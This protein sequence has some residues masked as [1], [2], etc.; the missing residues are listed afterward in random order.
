[1]HL[2]AARNGQL[3]Y[4]RMRP[5]FKRGYL[6][7]LSNQV[8]ADASSGHFHLRRLLETTESPSLEED[9][10]LL[11]IIGSV[12][13]LILLLLCITFII[14][15][16]YL[17]RRLP[18][19][20]GPKSEDMVTANEG[21]APRAVPNIYHTN[22]SLPKIQGAKMSDQTGNDMPMVDTSVEYEEL[23][24]D[25]KDRRSSPEKVIQFDETGAQ[26]Y[27]RQSKMPVRRPTGYPRYKNRPDSYSEP[28]RMVEMN[29]VYSEPDLPCTGLPEMPTVNP[30]IPHTVV[31]S[32]KV[33]SHSPIT[34]GPIGSIPRAVTGTKVPT[35][36]AVV[37]YPVPA[38]NHHAPVSK[39]HQYDV[40]RGVDYNR[41]IHTTQNGGLYQQP[42]SRL[43]RDSRW[44][45]STSGYPHQAI[46]G[47]TGIYAP[48]SA[49]GYF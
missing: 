27:K 32:K 34:Q 12:V 21:G 47:A 38:R 16:I 37:L 36:S 14:V 13:V 3:I 18:S 7:E 49:D 40:P 2:A 42:A 45:W 9:P 23:A 39:Q 46:R 19:T 25:I 30:P 8:I 15:M 33:P 41:F 43:E 4:F 44:R 17:C 1:M 20:D 10:N 11:L 24:V 35:P 31:P 5:T 22:T 26:P 28:D 48:A 6:G 29:R